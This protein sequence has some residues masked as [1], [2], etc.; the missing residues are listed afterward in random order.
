[1]T[2]FTLPFESPIGRLTLVASG[3]ALVAIEFPGRAPSGASGAGHA[4]LERAREQLREYF[5]GRR[6]AFD[7]PLAP[8][9]TEFQRAVWR[10]I[11]AIPF[12]ETLSYAEVA[13]RVGRPGAARAVG[14][15]TGRNPIPLVVPCHR[16]VGA[17]GSLTGFGGGLE[18]K[19]WLLA[20]EG[21]RR[22]R[23]RGDSQGVLL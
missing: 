15:A 6:T 17:D 4:V 2:H 1:M 16:V 23:M 21:A 9:G 18:T 10:E 14:A 12:G 22:A 8:R 3:E 13:R 20:H 11:A 5:A 7:L 19:R